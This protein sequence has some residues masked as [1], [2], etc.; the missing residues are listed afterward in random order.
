[1]RIA[2]YAPLK[3]PDHPV[4]SGDRKM[5]RQLIAALETLGH[6]VELASRFR[7]RDGD[8]HAET[9]MR[10]RT[11]GQAEADA[12]AAG[13][14][15]G[16]GMPPDLWFTYHLYYKAPDWIGPRVAARLGIPYVAAEAS[17]AP[18]R[19]GGPWALGHEGVLRALAA[20]RSVFVMTPHDRECL[21][22]ALGPQTRLLDLPPFLD[23]P[24]PPHPH[25]AHAARRPG[26]VR[27]V[28]TAMMR[29]G[30][31]LASYRFLA[32][33]LMSLRDLDWRLLVLGDG[34]ARGEVE[35]AFAPF[36]GRM[37]FR[38]A[39]APDTVP[40]LLREGDLFVWPGM[41]EAY[42]L[43]YL[44]AQGA[45]LPVV[46]QATRGVPAVVR[47]GETGLLTPEG[48]V[49]AFAGAL[50]RLIRDRGLRARFSAAARAFVTRE[51]SRDT[52]AAVLD[53]GLA[54]ALARRAA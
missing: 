44:E 47:A 11:A 20:A 26:P 40:A 13:W 32:R 35:A 17:L 24:H 46:A 45:G 39:V 23:T 6:R 16:A 42:G 25:P 7:S 28:V 37:D 21:A 27:L 53:A 10:L 29:P 48:D 1:M 22:P 30:D 8:G 34:D 3:P 49:D 19:A 33:A 52:A 41:G 36:R 15:A 2:F 5:A 12:L 9:Q 14:E 51:R 38:G 4:P 54:D 18:K 31:K 50:R 43:A